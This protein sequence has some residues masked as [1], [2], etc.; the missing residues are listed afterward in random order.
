MRQQRTTV[1]DKEKFYN[2]SKNVIE[3]ILKEDT[4]LIMGNFNIQI[5]KEKNV[6]KAAGKQAIIMDK[7]LVI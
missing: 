6:E 2:F 7:Y 5:G 1:E 3:K 4:R